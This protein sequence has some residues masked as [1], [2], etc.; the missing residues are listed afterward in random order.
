MTCNVDTDCCEYFTLSRI[1]YIQNLLRISSVT[2]L[3]LTSLYE[4]TFLDYAL[5]KS[6]SSFK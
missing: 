5:S 2:T 6:V 4:V 3:L 1:T